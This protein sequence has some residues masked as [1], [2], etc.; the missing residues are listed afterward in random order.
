MIFLHV[1][2]ENI[3]EY[4]FSGISILERDVFIIVFNPPVNNVQVY[5][6]TSGGRGYSYMLLTNRSIALPDVIGYSSTL[7]L[8]SQDKETNVTILFSSKNTTRVIYGVLTNNNTYY[9]QM[10]SKSYVFAEGILFILSPQIV[11]P[12]GDSKI[13]FNI[14]VVT[15]KERERG[16]HIELPPL[17]ITIPVLAAIL[18]IAYFNAYVIIDSYYLSQKEELS[19]GRKI[20]ILLLLLISAMAIY[21]LAGL[22]IKF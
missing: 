1:S 6:T 2:A 3:T 18:F 20:G 19:T 12:S 4:S 9:R 8:V 21:W 16:F 11:M 14:D 5:V 15:V 17:A 13:V 7:Q 22:I 10:S